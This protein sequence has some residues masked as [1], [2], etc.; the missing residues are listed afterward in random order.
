MIS[1]NIPKL[2]VENPLDAMH[3]ACRCC[4]HGSEVGGGLKMM[5]HTAVR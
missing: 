4:A 2:K 3:I 1:L 5:K